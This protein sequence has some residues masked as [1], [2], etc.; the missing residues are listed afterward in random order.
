MH[1]LVLEVK[2]VRIRVKIVEHDGTP[3]KPILVETLCD[4]GV[5][6]NKIVESKEAFFLITDMKGMDFILRDE[7]RQR[8]A[9]K[10]FEVQYPPEFEAERTVMLRNVDSTISAMTEEQIAELIGR[11]FKVKKVIKIPN[12]DHLLKIVFDNVANAD[13]AVQDGLKIKFQLFQNRNI[14]K[15]VFVPVVPCYRCYSYEHFKKNCPKNEQYKIC[16]NCATEGHVHTDCKATQLRCINCSQDHRTLAAKC[17]VR[18]AI[19]RDKIKERKTRSQSTPKA[20]VPIQIT[21]A[22]SSHTL[23]ENYLAVM[24]A[25]ITIADKREAEVPG[26]F[27]NIVTEMLAANNIPEVKFPDSV[28]SGYKA[29]RGERKRQRTSAEE[30][31]P[32]QSSQ[33]EQQE[34]KW[35]LMPDGS[36]QPVSRGTTPGVTPDPTPTSTPAITPLPTPVSSPQRV[37]GAVAKRPKQREQIK[38]SEP[39]LVLIVRSDISLPE[40]MNNQQL[41]N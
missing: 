34:T 5:W 35:A 30:Q 39:G 23:P 9:L 33:K 36:W 40:N 3:K 27:N 4:V 20:N 10:G 32:Q 18:K 37:I 12:A 22:L 13:R 16:S 25:T 6:V 14:E 7:T 29:T 24:A 38:E 28:I 26:I 8:L 41:K 17:S 31:Q 2:K 11:D 15:E 1:F 21:P 19:I